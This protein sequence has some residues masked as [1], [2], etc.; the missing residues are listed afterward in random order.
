MVESSIAARCC[1]LQLSVVSVEFA[2]MALFI[3]CILTEL[4]LYCYYG[5]EVTVEVSKRAREQASR[6]CAACIAT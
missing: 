2:S 1:V 6:Y 5:N 3:S 4:F